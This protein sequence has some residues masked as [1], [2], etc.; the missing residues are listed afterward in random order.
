MMQNTVDPSINL[1]VTSRAP[2]INSKSLFKIDQS[3]ITFPKRC[4]LNVEAENITLGNSDPSSKFVPDLRRTRP[5]VVKFQCNTTYTSRAELT[6]P[7]VW[8]IY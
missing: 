5:I 1:D 4:I 7:L 2:S 6:L 3:G 8:N